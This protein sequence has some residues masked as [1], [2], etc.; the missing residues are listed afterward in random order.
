MIGYP[1]GQDVSPVRD[2]PLFPAR[3]TPRE[4]YNKSFINQAC[5]VNMAGYLLASLTFLRVYRPRPV[6]L[7][8]HTKMNLAN[9]Q[10]SHLDRTSLVNNPYTLCAHPTKNVNVNLIYSGHALFTGMPLEQ[11]KQ[12]FQINVT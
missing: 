2:Y 7:Y 3:K 8:K 4:P 11:R 1:S 12:I 5:L 10:A 9:I 6:S